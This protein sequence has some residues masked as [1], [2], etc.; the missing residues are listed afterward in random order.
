MSQNLSQNR[1]HNW[2]KKFNTKN[3]KSQ[4]MKCHKMWHFARNE[5]SQKRIVTKYEMSHRSSGYQGYQVYLS[6]LAGLS[7]ISGLAGIVLVGLSSISGQS[8]KS[9]L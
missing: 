8:W 5:K 4:N 3:E 6:G 7:G 1:P 9:G 2:S